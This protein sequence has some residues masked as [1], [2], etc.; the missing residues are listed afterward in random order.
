MKGKCLKK[1]KLALSFLV[2]FTFIMTPKFTFA[3]INEVD[4]SM[5]PPPPDSA[6]AARNG[7][8][9][10]LTPAIIAANI[11]VITAVAVLALSN[12]SDAHTHAH[13]H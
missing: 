5:F 7:E 10:A 2:F 8:N 13:S 12:S 3:A 11:G 9:N 4:P 1:H 6:T